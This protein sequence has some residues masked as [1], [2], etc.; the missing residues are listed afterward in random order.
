LS[1]EFVD[2]ERKARVTMAEAAIGAIIRVAD[3]AS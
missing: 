1:K 2:R 3:T